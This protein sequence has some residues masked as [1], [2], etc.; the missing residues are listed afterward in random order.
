MK[1]QDKVY[2]NKFNTNETRQEAKRL[3]NENEFVLTSTCPASWV[4]EV[5]ELLA[6]LKLKFPDIAF[7]R[8][9]EDF[10][11]LNLQYDVVGS[12]KEDVN[13]VI[14]ETEKILFDKGVYMEGHIR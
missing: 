13:A 1:I 14:A 5:R 6:T 3:I 11:K 10:G 7:I 12:K 4:G 9:T 8:L 2:N